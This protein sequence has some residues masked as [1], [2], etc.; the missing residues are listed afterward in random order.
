[1][2]YT[3]WEPARRGY[4]VIALPLTVACPKSNMVGW[5]YI[6]IYSWMDDHLGIGHVLILELGTHVSRVV[7]VGLL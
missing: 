7:I 3:V 4:A 5:V 1:M 2:L 6:Y